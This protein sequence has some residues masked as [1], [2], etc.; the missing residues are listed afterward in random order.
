[1]ETTIFRLERRRLFSL[2]F[3]IIL[4]ELTDQMCILRKTDID[5][6]PFHV[7]RTDREV[8]SVHSWKMSASVSWISFRDEC[9]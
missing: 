5:G 2:I 8:F 4:I 1:L 6:L 3:L 7:I 9:F